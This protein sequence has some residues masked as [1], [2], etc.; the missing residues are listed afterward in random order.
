MGKSE[1]R[2]VWRVIGGNTLVCADRPDCQVAVKLDVK[3]G[4][5]PGVT[6][7]ELMRA[8]G[9]I[10]RERCRTRTAG[11]NT[12]TL[13]LKHGEIEKMEKGEHELGP[14]FINRGEYDANGNL[15]QVA[16]TIPAES[17][18][19][20]AR[21]ATIMRNALIAYGDADEQA[22]LDSVVVPRTLNG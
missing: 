21:L 13:P 9:I 8:V 17:E 4:D 19:S 3:V 5:P 16:F 22:F 20:L 6:A 10:T 11:E 7:G 14:W 1:F 15:R 2:P 18:R 12:L